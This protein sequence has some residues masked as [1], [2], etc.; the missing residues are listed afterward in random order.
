MGENKECRVDALACTRNDYIFECAMKNPTPAINKFS[1][2]GQSRT[3]VPT[4]F[5]FFLQNNGI[6]DRII[7]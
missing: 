2:N 6:Y 4:S 3:P 5:I 1:K 7:A